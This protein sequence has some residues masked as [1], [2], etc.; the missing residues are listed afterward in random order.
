MI[1]LLRMYFSLANVLQKQTTKMYGYQRYSNVF[2]RLSFVVKKIKKE[3]Y[4]VIFHYTF[5]KDSF[6]EISLFL[7][8]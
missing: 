8:K 5:I 4:T 6:I 3:K 1:N 2:N 7:S